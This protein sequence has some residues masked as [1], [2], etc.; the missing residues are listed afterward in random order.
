M[1]AYIF[2]DTNILIHFI[3]FDQIK[4][5]EIVNFNDITLIIVP[6]VVSELDKLKFDNNEKIRKRAQIS[7]RQLE[8]YLE[9][10]LKLKQLKVNF[11]E[12][13]PDDSIFKKCNLDTSLNDDRILASILEFKKSNENVFIATADLGI[14]IKLKSLGIEHV[15]PQENLK[16]D[17]VKDAR[18]EKIKSLEDEI[19]K[20][21]NSKPKLKL[22][23]KG[24][25]QFKIF[26]INNYRTPENY[27]QNKVIEVK[28]MY[29]YKTLEEEKI[30]NDA[31]IF[32]GFFSPKQEYIDVYNKD[33]DK[34]FR[35]YEKYIVKYEEYR[36]INCKS[37]KLELSLI[38]EGTFPANDVRIRLHFPDGM[39]LIDKYEFP[40]KPIAPNVPVIFSGTS[41]FNL[42]SKDNLSSFVNVLGSSK[43]YD[44]PNV[45]RFH[46]KK[47][48]SFE[49]KCQIK[50]LM[51]KSSVNLDD[52]FICYN[53]IE[54]ANSFSFEY[55]IIAE[56]VPEEI[57]GS[58]N[59]II[60]NDQE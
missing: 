49:V 15:V 33:L 48:N 24:E 43:N 20:I 60:K 25:E 12:S 36:V 16:I 9:D 59:V 53:S 29:P 42:L 4:W 14:R 6:T 50:K 7:I 56:N 46:I 37:C 55:F 47:S 10:P 13:E 57:T 35:E 1:K 5:N 32:K 27:V 39:D 22:L 21:K 31:N 38:N 44:T 54:N 30:K 51:H 34:Y 11:V 23:F 45:S 28:T 52:L 3:P 58:L 19:K 40:R 41:I 8:K 26:Q 2:L 18:D 17:T